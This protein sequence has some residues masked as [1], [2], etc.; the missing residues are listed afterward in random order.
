MR[1]ASVTDVA[2]KAGVSIG[3]VSNVLNHPSRVS[4]QTVKRVQKAISELGF[5][6]NDAARQLKAGNSR[7]I[8]LV[9]PDAS[10]PFF[11]ELSKG[12][13][14]YALEKDFAVIIGN[15]SENY[16]RETGYINLFHEQRVGGVL[17][18]PVRD[19]RQ[20]VEELNKMGINAVIVDREAEA[21]LCCS[22]S[23]DDV[24]GGRLA[25]RHLIDIGCQHIAFVGGGPTIQQTV[26][27]LEG[28]RRELAAHPDVRLSVFE[29][30]EMNVM[31]GRTA[32]G[33]IENLEPTDRP[34][35]IFAANDLIGVGMLQALLFESKVKV[36]E[37]IAMIGYDDI[38]FAKSTIVPL[39]SVKQP[40]RLLGSSAVELL[41]AELGDPDHVHRQVTFQP[42]IVIRQSSNRKPRKHSLGES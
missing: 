1:H 36:P 3:T 23:V 42:E 34:D 16:G 12:A 19:V 24:S 14:D 29:T 22:V 31:A 13:E 30:S 25:A 6:R 11:A 5:V 33:F 40:A 17:I 2:K 7:T 4:P 35:G 38:D 9:L 18:S 8:G 37:E 28:V 39:S 10:N 21:S 27:R 15:S 32:G 20:R 26:D 41:I